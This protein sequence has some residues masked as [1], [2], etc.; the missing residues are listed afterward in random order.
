MIFDLILNQ[1]III[2]DLPDCLIGF[3]VHYFV[4]RTESFEIQILAEQQK[5]RRFPKR[6]SELLVRAFYGM[7]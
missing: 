1:E 2:V 4:F 3:E 7:K 5:I 6:A